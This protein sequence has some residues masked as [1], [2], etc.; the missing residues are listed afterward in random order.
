MNGVQ[1]SIVQCSIVYSVLLCT[2]YLKA[3]LEVPGREREGPPV[4]GMLGH[5]RVALGGQQKVLHSID[6]G[7][8][9]SHIDHLQDSSSNIG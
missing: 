6:R 4:R 3:Q 5:S 9:T 2:I 7:N 1:Y 8:K